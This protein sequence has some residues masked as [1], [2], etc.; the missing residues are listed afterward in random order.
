MKRILAIIPAGHQVGLTTVSLGLVRAL[1]SKGYRTGF[2]KPIAQ[3][4]SRSAS[5]LDQSSLIL[6]R[7]CSIL[8]PHPIHLEEAEALLRKGEDQSLME[9]V[10]ELYSHASRNVD[11]MVVEGMVSAQNVFFAKRL[12]NLI[13]ETLDA[14][15]ILVSSAQESSPSELAEALEIQARE[16]SN[17]AE[18]AVIGCVVNKIGK[19]T[20][21]GLSKL[22]LPPTASLQQDFQSEPAQ[23]DRLV[24]SFK[25]KVEKSNMAVLATIPYKESFTSPRLKDLVRAMDAHPIHTGLWEDRRVKSITLAGQSL[26]KTLPDLREGALLVCSAD[27]EEILLAAALAEL[28]NIKLAGI[29]LSGT[30]EPGPNVMA[31]IGPA[32]G[33]G[34]P[35]IAIAKDLYSVSSMLA[36]VR[37]E[38][39][40]DDKEMTMNQMDS[41]ASEFEDHWLKKLLDKKREHRTSPAAFRNYLLNLAREQ[42]KRI[43]LP[44][45]DEPRTVEA[46]I[47]SYEKGMATPILLAKPEVVQQIAQD[48]GLS[49]PSGIE[50]I[51]PESLIDQMVGPMVELRKSKGLT[52][53][54]ARELLS[55]PIYVGTMMLKLGQADG[56]VSGAVHTS[57]NTVKPALQLIKCVPGVDTVSS[58]FFMCLPNQVMVYGDCAIVQDPTAEQLASI[59]IQSADSAKAFNIPQRVAMVSYSTGESGTGADVEKVRAATQ[60][61]RE[62]RP[63]IC[64]DGPLQ[65]DAAVNHSV[66]AKKAPNSDVA[67]RATVIIFPDL[68]TGNTTYKAVQRSAHVVSIG[69]MLQGLKKP[70]NDLSRGAL[71]DD[72]IYTIALTAIQAGQ[73]ITD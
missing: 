2:F 8:S 32:L 50:V 25:E 56:L 57:A 63:D 67:G 11:V 30:L 33:R 3:P 6:E 29:L 47:M 20:G 71:V 26:E 51:D 66:A 72:I 61:V 44:E 53:E 65:Y 28:K 70:V 12:N 59:A 23:I 22:F 10:A 52:E 39:P 15:V 17:D 14:E 58:I 37:P 69:P 40:M 64:I 41:V 42:N 34:L 21:K 35:L 36:E 38:I 73:V 48:R 55:D 49:I 24:S 54:K 9:R 62:Q 46:A 1:L 4:D 68:N 31:M 19:P 43:V 18:N 13:I 5:G 27:R 45:G 60:L 16:Y 7:Y